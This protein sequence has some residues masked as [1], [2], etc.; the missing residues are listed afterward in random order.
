MPALKAGHIM[1]QALE[2][3]TAGLTI[4][5]LYGLLGIGINIIFVG[6][7]VP[8]FAQGAFGLVAAYLGWQFSSQGFPIF[9]ALLIGVV[10]SALLGFAT[11][12]GAFSKMSGASATSMMLFT[13]GL[14][15]FVVNAVLLIWGPQTK[16]PQSALPSGSLQVAGASIQANNLMLIAIVGVVVL[17]VAL[18]FYKTRVGLTMRAGAENAAFAEYMGINSKRLRSQIWLLSGSLAGIAGSLI[19]MQIALVPTVMDNLLIPAFTACAIGGFTSIMGGYI[20]GLIIGVAETMTASYV[21]ADYQ[22]LTAVVLL[23]VVLIVRPQ[24]LFG[25]REVRVA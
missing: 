18:F 7:G 3:L 23:L 21:S 2:L 13:L 19:A 8:N 22:G 15:L 4:G 10:A 17:A 24:G 1:S 11:D 20:G 25:T 9:L 12:R 16:V 5:S 6:S 14:S